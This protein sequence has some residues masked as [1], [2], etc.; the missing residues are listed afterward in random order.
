MPRVG[1]KPTI[2]LLERAKKRHALV[3]AAIVIGQRFLNSIK[4]KLRMRKYTKT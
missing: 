2:P 3:R 1:S 4:Y